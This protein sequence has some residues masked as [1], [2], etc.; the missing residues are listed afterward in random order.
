MTDHR[1]HSVEAL[2]EAV[3]IILKTNSNLKKNERE[4][5]PEPWKSESWLCP[6]PGLRVIRSEEE[7]GHAKKNVPTEIETNFGT[8]WI[9]VAH[10]LCTKSM[11]K[12]KT[13]TAVLTG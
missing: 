7:K 13:K 3:H 9:S 6:G 10:E 4:K 1:F 11:K 2:E 12:N 8:N 5:K